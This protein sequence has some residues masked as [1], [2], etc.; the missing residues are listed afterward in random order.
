MDTMFMDTDTWSVEMFIDYQTAKAFN[1]KGVDWNPGQAAS[2]VDPALFAGRAV[3]FKPC[4][5][6]HLLAA[7]YYV[8]A[9][10]KYMVEG[11]PT[12]LCKATFPMNMPASLF[13][14]GD[15]VVRPQTETIAFTKPMTPE[16]FPG[17]SWEISELTQSDGE[18][19]LDLGRQQLEQPEQVGET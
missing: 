8:L 18:A 7:K 14:N 5:M 11:P 16:N 19:M 15:I 12:H 17:L 2:G 10:R 3:P 6:N 1:G 9:L 13:L 4:S